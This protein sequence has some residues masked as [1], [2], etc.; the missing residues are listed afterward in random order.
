MAKINNT[1]QY[2]LKNLI[3]DKFKEKR[4]ALSSEIDAIKKR[5]YEINEENKDK[6]K[7]S[8]IRV[9]RKAHDDV[10]KLLKI[11]GLEIGGQYHG[12]HLTSLF[13]CGK[14]RDNWKEYIQPI[15]KKGAKQLLLEKDLTEL[16]TK[17]RKAM[18]ELVLR[19]NLGCKYDEVVSFINNLE[20]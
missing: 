11:G 10:T 12:T 16:D 8:I 1:T 18:D 14:L 2:I 7:E 17:C 9:M 3:L 20:V 5:N 6:C 4:E 19:A 15:V 13:Y